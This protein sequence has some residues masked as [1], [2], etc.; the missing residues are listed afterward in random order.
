VLVLKVFLSSTFL[1]LLE[2]REAVLEALHK[3]QISTLA[4]E[5]FVASPNTPLQTALDKLRKSD[6]MVLVI[7][8][9][10]GS[11]LPDGSSATYT[12]AEYDEWLRLGRAP[13]LFIKTKAQPG[14]RLPLWCNE[15]D[16]EAKRAALADF[17]AR[18]SENSTPAYFTTP[19]KL[20]LEVI[21]ALDQWE[22]LGRPGARKTF[23]STHEYFQGKNPAG[24]FQI[25]DFNTTLLG[26]K[27]QIRA[28]DAFTED[29]KQRVCILSG[30]G[31]IGKSKILY[32]WANSHQEAVIFL[33]DAPLWY[34]DSEKEIPIKCKTL[35]VDD[36]H[37]QETFGKVLQLLQDTA[38]HRN[39]K[40]IVSTRPGSANLLAQ[41][42][43]RRIDSTQLLELPELQELN[44]EQSRVLAEQVLGND[45]R[46]FAAHLAEIG[47]NS[48]LVI[49]AGG[50]LLRIV[51]ST[52]R[53]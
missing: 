8:F 6:V 1:D 31:G 52:L 14:Q 42:V 43:L 10:A 51:R 41:Q 46:N 3:K 23:A 15:E 35:I 13:L 28:L 26:R 29:N 19:D 7:G 4:M 32:D 9:K 47:S 36:A 25:L 38:G 37:R 27:D 40:L 20:A 22:A 44:K 53:R 39:L 5:Y 30:R 34:E 45:F 11:L 33:K 21:F 50:V 17:K 12:S 18:A 24:Q 2:E 49:V 48:P 16:N